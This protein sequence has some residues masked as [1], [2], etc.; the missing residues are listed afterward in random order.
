MGC[1]GVSQMG[2]SIGQAGANIGQVFGG[3]G[4][5]AQ[6]ASNAVQGKSAAIIAHPKVF[7]ATE[8]NCDTSAMPPT[9]P[10]SNVTIDP[11]NASRFDVSVTQ[12]DKIGVKQETD[13]LC[14]AACTE[15]LLRQQNIQVQQKALAH[16]Y[17][18]DDDDGDDDEGQAAGLGVMIRA[19]NPDLEP[20]LDQRGV[21][22]IDLQAT[23]SDQMLS[24]LMSG[25]LCIV[26]LVQ[27]DDTTMGHACVVCGA[28]FGKLE[29][30]TFALMNTKVTVN[31]NA[32]SDDSKAAQSAL[33]PTYGLYSVDLFDP[34]TGKHRTISGQDFA[35][36]TDF[37]T[38]H[39]LAHDILVAALNR[40]PG[41][42]M[43]AN[44]LVVKSKKY[45]KNARLAR[46]RQK[47]DQK[48]VKTPTSQP[49]KQT[50]KQTVK[51]QPKSN[52]STK[53]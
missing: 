13:T 23:T 33:T 41:S 26:G 51:Q 21:V 2:S 9:A 6:T 28:T 19:L 44:A 22:P 48:A 27:K 46:Y 25:R 31:N 8:T 38:S 37:L 12:I 3:K 45:T 39:Q 49:V 4:Q 32:N 40:P 17:V 53:K 47:P 24:E 29:P 50:V 36:Q 14:W 42:P 1:G 18:A 30:N 15:I 52:E 7:V 35:D 20:Q 43:P 34:Y 5:P 11:A 10:A 16:E